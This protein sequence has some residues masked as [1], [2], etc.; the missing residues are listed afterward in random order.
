MY[1]DE[2]ILLDMDDNVIGMHP[3]ISSLRSSE[4]PSHCLCTCFDALRRILTP[5]RTARSQ[6]GRISAAPQPWR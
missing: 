1:K 2:C 3:A 5:L 4:T 6:S